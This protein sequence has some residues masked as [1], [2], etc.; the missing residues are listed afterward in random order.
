[1]LGFALVFL[2]YAGG[3]VLDAIWPDTAMYQEIRGYEA[4]RFSPTAATHSFEDERT[5]AR[6]G[7]AGAYAGELVERKIVKEPKDAKEAKEI[8][9][10]ALAGKYRSTLQSSY[11]QDRNDAIKKANDKLNDD[12]NAKMSDDER[13]RERRRAFDNH[14]R[15]IRAA[16]AKL[17]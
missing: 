7:M 15:A 1:M 9:D 8:K 6:E 2:V 11:V 17:D 10:A 3:R 16:K 14:A 4:F 12:L 5:E 13:P